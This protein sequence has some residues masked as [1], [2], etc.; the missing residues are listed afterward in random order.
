MGRPRSDA[1]AVQRNG[2]AWFKREL[3]GIIKNLRGEIGS[4]QD[5]CDRTGMAIHPRM[6]GN[7]ENGTEPRLSTYLIMCAALGVNPFDMLSPVLR[8]AIAQGDAK[9]VAAIVYG[10]A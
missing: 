9:G 7:H 2:S 8:E 4:Q 6:M 10:S 1:Q 5:F 3:A